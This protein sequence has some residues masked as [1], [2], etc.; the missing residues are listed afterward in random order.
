MVCKKKISLESKKDRFT[1][2][3][4]SVERHLLYLHACII[5]I[6]LASLFTGGCV[7]GKATVSQ[8][9]L[10]FIDRL[11]ERGGVTEEEW[12]RAAGEA[13]GNGSSVE[14]GSSWGESAGGAGGS[15]GETG[16]YSTPTQRYVT[17]TQR[18][19]NFFI[20][21]AEGRIRRMDIIST[22]YQPVGDPNSSYV[23]F[24]IA[25]TDA[26][27]ANGTLVM[28]FESG[29][30]RIAAIKG[31][32]GSLGGGTNYRPPSSFEEVLAA[33]LVQHQDFLT[34]LAEGRVR[35]LTVDSISHPS[36]NESILYG[37]VV[38]RSGRTENGEMHLRKDYNLW[39][40]TYVDYR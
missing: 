14:G 17:E 2:G 10:T 8:E 19:Q 37:V 7:K 23:Y 32:S 38:G 30:W 34:K 26:G 12:I 1:R 13:G 21:L 28:K 4:A 25:T 40:I 36:A 24:S 22:D 27:R 35:Y 16:G 5:F 31:L 29:L 15:M 9:Q 18:H 11:I 20:A 6:F 3:T 39:H 33:E